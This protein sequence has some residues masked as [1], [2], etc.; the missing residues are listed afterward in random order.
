MRYGAAAATVL[1]KS[2]VACI[3]SVVHPD[4]FQHDSLATIRYLPDPIGSF[5]TVA[6]SRMSEELTEVYV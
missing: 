1:L 4:M 2:T 3:G 6:I 5:V